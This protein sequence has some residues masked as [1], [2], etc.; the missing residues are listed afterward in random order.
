MNVGRRNRTTVFLSLPPPL[1]ADRQRVVA[2]AAASVT[3][4]VVL[5]PFAKTP[6]TT[7]LGFIPIHQSALFMSDAIVLDRL[8]EEEALA[9]R[10]PRGCAATAP[11]MRGRCRNLSARSTRPNGFRRRWTRDERA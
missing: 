11:P 2:M 3:I 5:A 9:A 6:L 1:K 8:D 10:T 4:F 7:V